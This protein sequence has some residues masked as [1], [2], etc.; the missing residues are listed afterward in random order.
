MKEAY[1]LRILTVK[2]AESFPEIEAL[3]LFGS[4][5]YRTGSMRS[6]MEILVEVREGSHVR[7]Q[8]LTCSPET[9]Q[10]W[11]PITREGTTS[12][13]IQTRPA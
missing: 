7:P 6:D 4:R 12:A 9:A 8:E 2:L 1:D 3:Y 5:R 11:G 10:N 13:Q